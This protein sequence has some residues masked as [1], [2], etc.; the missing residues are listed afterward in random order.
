MS[1]SEHS[2]TGRTALITGSTGGLGLA[3]AAALA[4]SGCNIVLSGLEPP[5]TGDAQAVQLARRAG[6]EAL[7]CRADLAREAGVSE[8]F[9][10]ALTRFG[11]IDVLV[12]NAVIR[13]FAPIET[14]APAQWEHAMA[15]NVTAGF[16]AIRRVL[17]GMRQRNWGR[18]VNM[19]SIYGQRGAP[20]RAD[21]I[22]TKAALV[23]L[24]R[25]VAAETAKQDI[26]CNAVCPGSVATPGTTVRI[27]A[28]MQAEGIPEDE[29]V[30]RFLTG[31]QPSGRFVS[32]ESVAAMVVFLCGP[33]GRDITGAVLPIDG[34]WL[35][36]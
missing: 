17:P 7:Y 31:K 4:Q 24:T 23:G 28:L 5:E 6:V 12:N 33:A 14:L 32:A 8:L 34:G 26:T 15:V 25:A 10:R 27:Q 3:I 2:L 30:S 16:L 29:A 18:I 20:D 22:T 13:H 21:Y 19:S 35:A 11:T 36:S 9:D 1:T